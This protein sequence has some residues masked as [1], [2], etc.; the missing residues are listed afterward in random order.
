[1]IRTN[2][3]T[4]PFYNERLVRLG[5]LVFLLVV[6]V[7]TLFNVTRVVRYSRSDTQL[8]ERAAR[9]EARAAELREIG[10]ALCERPLPEADRV[11]IAQSAPGKRPYRPPYFFLD[12]DLQPVRVRRYP[13]KSRITSSPVEDRQAA[14]SSCRSPIER[15]ALK[16]VSSLMDNMER[17]GVFLTGRLQPSRSA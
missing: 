7:A 5:L 3:S 11:C 4:R 1:M 17:T 14:R 15:A 9:D 6:A 2:L 12:A 16:E 8:S 10:R 13:T